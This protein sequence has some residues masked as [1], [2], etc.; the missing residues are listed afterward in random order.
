[1]PLDLASHHFWVCV[2]LGV[3]IA[4]KIENLALKSDNEEVQTHMLYQLWSL[5]PL[6]NDLPY[7]VAQLLPLG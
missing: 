2:S 7:Y 4:E 3:E 6:Y 1:M 5:K